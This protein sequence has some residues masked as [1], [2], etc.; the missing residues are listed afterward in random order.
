MCI[1]RIQINKYNT[2]QYNTIQY[3]TIQYNTIK[4]VVFTDVHHNK[5]TPKDE[6]KK[7]NPQIYQ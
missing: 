6:I 4:S 2:I 3:N 7:N 5:I 1:N